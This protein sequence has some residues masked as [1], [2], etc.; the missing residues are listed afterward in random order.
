MKMKVTLSNQQFDE[1][2]AALA[3]ANDALAATLKAKGVYLES[4]KR[5]QQL[6]DNYL[7]KLTKP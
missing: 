1:I 6:R 3:R 4:V 5:W 2:K 7:E